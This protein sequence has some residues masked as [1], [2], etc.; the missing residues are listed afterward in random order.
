MISTNRLA[1]VFVE[2]A[3]T[4]VD[5]FDLVDFLNNVTAHAAEITGW[6]AVGL[7]LS[8]AHGELHY[9]ASSTE[10][11]R[12]ME[13]LQLQDSEGPCVDCHRTGEPVASADLGAETA[14]WPLFAPQ[15]AAAGFQCVHAFP[16]RLRTQVIGA[17]NAFGV[18]P[19][20]LTEESIRVVQAL[21]D[22]A[23]IAIIQEQAI[24]QADTLTGQ[25]QYALNS[26]VII[27]QAKGAIARA[28]G[29][30]VEQAFTVLRN[31]ART[32][33]RRLTELA[34]EIVNDPAMMATLSRQ[35][36]RS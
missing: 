24:S 35:G 1:D 9:M 31:H 26:R 11:A 34:H 2:V 21:T 20:P 13:L 22:I 17:L 36:S 6:A 25:L 12:L 27:E 18:D 16:M 19:T 29:I 28:F 30:T 7:M 32:N 10:D 33:Q 3:D 23:T 15:A 8:D 4:L 14:R 5:D